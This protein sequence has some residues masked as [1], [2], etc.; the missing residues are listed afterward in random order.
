MCNNRQMSPFVLVVLITLLTVNVQVSC[1]LPEYRGVSLFFT[2]FVIAAFTLYIMFMPKILD[3]FEEQH[4]L[5][6][7]VQEYLYNQNNLKN[8][9]E[10]EAARALKEV[11]KTK[12]AEELKALIAASVADIRARQ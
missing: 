1:A 4:A 7:K 5:N 6:C 12:K 11:K 8:L 2:A 10:V 9:A 3:K